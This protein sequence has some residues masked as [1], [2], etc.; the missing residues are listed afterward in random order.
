MSVLVKVCQCL[1]GLIIGLVIVGELVLMLDDTAAKKYQYRMDPVGFVNRTLDTYHN[2][3]LKYPDMFTIP[4]GGYQTMDPNG[5]WSLASEMAWRMP[6]LSFNA[7]TVLQSGGWPLDTMYDVMLEG[8]LALTEGP[9]REH[10]WIAYD[11][12]FVINVE[13][14][15]RLTE[16]IIS[17]HPG[18]RWN[19]WISPHELWK[20]GGLKEWSLIVTRDETFVQKNRCV[21]EWLQQLTSTDYELATHLH[22][23]IPPSLRQIESPC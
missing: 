15:S 8:T 16:T 23:E 14:L 22:S 18:N 1:C 7:S 9:I 5:I 11:P 6:W 4:L 19:G 13:I 12:L 21:L 20:V 3:T 10:A 17:L 2:W